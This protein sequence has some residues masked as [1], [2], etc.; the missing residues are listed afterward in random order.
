MSTA[1]AALRWPSLSDEQL[2]VRY[3]AGER[4]CFDEL[5]QRYR[6]PI[7][8]FILRMVGRPEDAEDLTQDVFLQL[9]KSLPTARADLPLRPWVFV[10]A[11]NKCLDHLKRKRPLLFSAMTSAEADDAPE[12][13]LPDHQP[14]PEELAER[15]DLRDLLQ[16]AIESLPARYRTVV[17]LRYSGD[18]TFAE[19]GAVLALPENTAKTH[20]QRAKGLLR[21]AL[22]NLA[23]D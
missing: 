20:F 15:A 4:D 5:V 19:I 11:R 14:L 6:G 17:A 12:E 13:R 22:T 2:A 1:S 10:I 16:R 18:L 3:V 23:Y 9:L 21:A 8:A 7:H